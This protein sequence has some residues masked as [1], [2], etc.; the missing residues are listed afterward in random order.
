MLWN[1]SLTYGRILIQNRIESDWKYLPSIDN[2]CFFIHFNGRNSKR[3]DCANFTVSRSISLLQQEE[4]EEVE[5]EEQDEAEWGSKS[6][7]FPN[8]RWHNLNFEVITQTVKR[9]KVASILIH[10]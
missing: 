7:D 3:C 5:E 9:K 10:Q 4:D 1:D 6:E 8:G 2:I